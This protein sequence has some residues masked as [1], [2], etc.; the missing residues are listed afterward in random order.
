MLVRY[1]EEQREDFAHRAEAAWRREERARSKEILTLNA[2]FDT[3]Q[4]LY[5]EY[6]QEDTSTPLVAS[7]VTAGKQIQARIAY[8]T[9]ARSMA[10]SRLTDYL[11]RPNRTNQTTL[12]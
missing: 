8:A 7:L 1:D 3:L 12:K 10:L 9:D 6:S 2:A 5:Y 4:Q 11:K